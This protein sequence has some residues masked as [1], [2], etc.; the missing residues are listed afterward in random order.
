MLGGGEWIASAGHVVLRHSAVV[1]CS[2]DGEV[3]LMVWIHLRV[4]VWIRLRG[5]GCPS[6]WDGM[7]PSAWGWVSV[8]VSGRIDCDVGITCEGVGGGQMS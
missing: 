2:S 4:M 5:V 8:H 7:D 6:A 1:P 3:V